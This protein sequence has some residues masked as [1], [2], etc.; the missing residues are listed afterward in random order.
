M[1]QGP[2]V[3]SIRHDSSGSLGAAAQRFT[4]ASAPVRGRR[5]FAKRSGHIS[6]NERTPGPW[7]SRWRSRHE[8]VTLP[9]NINWLFVMKRGA[10]CC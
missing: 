1:R 4:P 7:A 9:T 8:P 5:A 10:G 2:G 6:H 3:L